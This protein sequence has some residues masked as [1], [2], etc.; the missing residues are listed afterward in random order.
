[1]GPQNVHSRVHNSPLLDPIRNQINLIKILTHFLQKGT[2]KGKSHPKTGHKVTDGEYRYISVNSALD[3]WVNTTLR[4]LYPWNDPEPT[5]YEDEYDQ[6]I[7]WTD[8]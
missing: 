1:M 8:A 3:V 4:P 2:G 6:G 5:V 7:V